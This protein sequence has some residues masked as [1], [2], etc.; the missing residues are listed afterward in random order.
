MSSRKTQYNDKYLPVNPD[1][2]EILEANILS[3]KSGKIHYFMQSMELG[4]ASGNIEEII[5][6]IDGKFLKA[7]NDLVRLDKVVTLFGIPGPAYE[8]YDRFANACLTCEDLGQF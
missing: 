4:L 6:D 5:T 2:V 8:T 3:N 7:G 1:F